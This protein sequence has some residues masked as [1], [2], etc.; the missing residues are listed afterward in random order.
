MVCRPVQRNRHTRPWMEMLKGKE[1]V[2]VQRE[3]RE[4]EA[5]TLAELP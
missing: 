4:A 5:A 1:V 2:G 3:V